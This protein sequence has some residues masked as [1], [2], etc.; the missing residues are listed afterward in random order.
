MRTFFKDRSGNVMVEFALSWA[1]LSVLFT[2]IFEYGYTMWTYN[3]MQTS[4]G[5]AAQAASRLQYD[6]SNPT[7]Y[8]NA[9]KNWAVYGTPTTGSAPIVPGMTTGNVVVTKD[10][11]TFPTVITVRVQNYTVN[12]LFGRKTFNKPRV[13]VKYMGLISCSGC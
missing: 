3:S 10:S 8:D 6:I 9:I 4:V 7:A 13:T 5:M 1:M 12:S 11:N 2:G